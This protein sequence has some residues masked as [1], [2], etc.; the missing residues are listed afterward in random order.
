MRARRGISPIVAT[1]IL[2]AVTIAAGAVVYSYLRGVINIASSSVSVQIQ[3]VDLVRTP[4]GTV[5]ISIT[6]RNSGSKPINKCE[7]VFYGGSNT[8]Y[9]IRLVGSGAGVDI[10]NPG[11]T[12]SDTVVTTVSDLNVVVGSSYLVK[13]SAQA[14]DGSRFDTVTSVSCSG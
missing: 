12:A 10:L 4:Q 5:L 11:Q 13:I 9:T 1:I 14:V 8:A 7:V 2:M 3:N 6:I